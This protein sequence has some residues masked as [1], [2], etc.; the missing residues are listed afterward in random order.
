MADFYE[1]VGAEFY[2]RDRS[3]QGANSYLRN[4]GRIQKEMGRMQRT[5]STGFG[6]GAGSIGIYGLQR[7]FRAVITEASNFEHQM[8]RVHTMLDQ[9]SERYLGQYG[10]AIERMSMK[11]GESVQ[12]LTSGTYDILSASIPASQAMRVLETNVRAAKGGFTDTATAVKGSIGI[13]NAYGMSAERIG[14]VTDLMHKVV[15]RGVITFEEL[16]QNI[17]TVT[18]LAAVLGVDLEAVGATIATMTRAGISAEISMTALRSI[19]NV[20]KTPTDAA[21]QAAAKLGFQLDATSIQGDGLITVVERLRNANAEQLDA[22]MP[23]VR[24][25]VGFAA[26][27]KNATKLSQDYAYMQSGTNAAM[28][29]FS[30]VQGDTATQMDITRE[31]WNSVKRSLGEMALPEVTRQLKE[32]SEG[33]QAINDIPKTV[34]SDKVDFHDVVRLFNVPAM[35]WDTYDVLYETPWTQTIEKYKADTLQAQEEMEKIT[36]RAQEQYLQTVGSLDP[37]AFEWMGISRGYRKPRFSEQYERFVDEQTRYAE[38]EKRMVAKQVVADNAAFTEMMEMAAAPEFRSHGM[39]IVSARQ[40]E[41]AATSEATDAV[42]KHFEALSREQE[43]IGRMDESR[44]RAGDYVETQ[45]AVA[46]LSDA[47]A[48]AILREIRLRK[49]LNALSPT[50]AKVMGEYQSRMEQ[51][52]VSEMV[53]DSMEDLAGTL[54]DIAFD[55]ENAEEYANKFFETLARN[56]TTELV[57]QPAVDAWKG[58]LSDAFRGFFAPTNTTAGGTNGHPSEAGR[59][60]AEPEVQHAGGVAGYGRSPTRR[61][62]ASVF[63][64]APRMATGGSIGYGEVPIIAHKGETILPAGTGFKMP[65]PTIHVYNETQTPINRADIGMEVDPHEMVVNIMLRDQQTGG[66]TRNM[67]G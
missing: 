28:E 62:P 6:L 41:T 9:G 16:A 42:R 59:S 36:R 1:R 34:I 56:A 19:L 66:P 51:L 52:R 22:L 58:A 67:V 25:L 7:G 37:R 46:Q 54:T 4:M 18:S 45:R 14:E 2:V 53:N 65:A 29:A 13:L 61:V 55:F 17:G 43:I 5:L 11:Y 31:K 47:E 63:A 39:P 40:A 35:I 48:E 3:A 27:L 8:S 30:K 20:F 60:Y 12:S 21:Q 44:F 50:Q 49:D 15:K 64:G 23:N 57:M 24:G 33:L 38:M 26:A 10:D 32:L